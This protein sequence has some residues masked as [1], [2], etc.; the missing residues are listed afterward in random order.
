MRLEASRRVGIFLTPAD[1]FDERLIQTIDF[2]PNLG[3]RLAVLGFY[4]W[5]SCRWGYASYPDLEGEFYL[6]R[7]RKQSDKGFVLLSS[8][9]GAWSL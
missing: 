7:G 4:H 6:R 1:D 5:E 3:E 8:F 2:R 9:S